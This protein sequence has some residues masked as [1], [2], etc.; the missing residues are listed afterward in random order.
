MD[1]KDNETFEDEGLMPALEAIGNLFK[2]QDLSGTLEELH[3]YFSEALNTATD[4]TKAATIAKTLQEL[5]AYILSWEY[6]DET[7]EKPFLNI[8]KTLLDGKLPHSKFE[9]FEPTKVQEFFERALALEPQ[10]AEQIKTR[11]AE[12]EEEFE[13]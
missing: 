12:P 5:S 11:L 13:E 3:T 1:E 2:M 4:Q 7:Y 6:A 10:L 8:C 9:S